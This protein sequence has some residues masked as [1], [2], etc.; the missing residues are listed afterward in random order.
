MDAVDTYQFFVLVVAFLVLP[1]SLSIVGYAFSCEST[2]A[3]ED[4]FLAKGFGNT[5]LRKRSS[6]PL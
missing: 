3:A 2:G 1:P 4:S 6:T 5:P